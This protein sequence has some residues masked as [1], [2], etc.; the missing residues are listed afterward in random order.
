MDE[1]GEIKFR[2][3]RLKAKASSKIKN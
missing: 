1:I 3:Y 2:F